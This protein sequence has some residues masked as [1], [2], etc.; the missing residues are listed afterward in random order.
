M[1]PIVYAELRHLA[2]HYLRGE[3]SDHTLQPTALVNEAYLRLTKLHNVDWQSRSHFLAMA[4]TVM[5]RILVD[6]ARAHAANKRE[7]FRE[8]ISLEETILVSAGRSPELIALDDALSRL[9]TI[10][11]RRSKI[12]ELRFFG[13]LSEEETGQLLGV[14]ARTVKRDWRVAKAWLYNEIN[15]K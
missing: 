2:A 13:G 3:R 8:A 14:S 10:D 7:G 11:T 1:I 4:A 5:R 15:G 12:V 9:A 6:H